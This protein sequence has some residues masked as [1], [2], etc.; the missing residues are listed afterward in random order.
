MNP[1]H[2]VK[3]TLEEI[4]TLQKFEKLDAFKHPEEWKNLE[5]DDLNL[6]ASLFVKKGSLDLPKSHELAEE[7]FETALKLTHADSTVLLKISRM[8]AGVEEWDRALKNVKRAL[9]QDDRLLE[10]WLELAA[11]WVLKGKALKDEFLF[12]EALHIFEKLEAM[13]LITPEAHFKW[14]QAY[15]CLARVSQEPFDLIRACEKYRQAEEGGFIDKHLFFDHA[16]A[17]SELATLLARSSYVHE[18]LT[19]LL[20]AVESDP[21]FH[22]GWVYLAVTYKFLYERGD[23][24]EYYDR[25]ESAFYT[26]SRLNPKAKMIWLSWGQMLL[27]EGRS[28]RNYEVVSLAIEKFER[29]NVIFPKDRDVQCFLADA[30]MV[31]GL[32]E[33]RF[34]LLKEAKEK[35]EECLRIKPD[36]AAVLFLYGTCLIH[37]GKYFQDEN[38]IRQSF[39]KFEK[40]I[41]LNPEDPHVW[42]SLALAHFTYG[43]MADDPI[44]LEKSVQLFEGCHKILNRSDSEL[45]NHWGVALMKLAETTAD[46]SFAL[47]AAEKFEQAIA[48]HQETKWGREADPEWYY[49]YGS[50]LDYLGNYF[51]DQSYFEK[52]VT[53]LGQ[54]VTTFPGYSHARYSFAVA[55]THYGDALSD[56]D[57]LEQALSHYDIL[58]QEDPEDELVLTEMGVALIAMGEISIAAESFSQSKYYFEEAE[59]HLL[60]ASSLGN[61]SAFFWLACLYACNSNIPEAIQYLERARDID[62]LPPYPELLEEKWLENVRDTEFWNPFLDTLQKD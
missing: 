23:K 55:L 60:Q 48:F 12:N 16:L 26:A 1:Q 49:N 46:P 59:T 19:Y 45:F 22:E 56:L 10:G 7:S 25:A 51:G 34:E 3:K 50:T 13:P 4:L 43:E 17:L 57:L 6:L 53:V 38:V 18:S 14:G 41:R 31:L 29:A 5:K 61:S 24:A 54:I 36:D 28:K 9:E 8:W 15:H 62:A 39:D 32:F 21:H 35:I 52:A 47:K 33:D 37:L 20:K 44:M 30:L 42:H 27:N 11:L 40:S 58:I 2:P